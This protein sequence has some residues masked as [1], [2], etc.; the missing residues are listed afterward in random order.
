[1][2]H[3][4]G[5]PLLL[6]AHAFMSE[7][8]KHREACIKEMETFQD[9][10]SSYDV[11]KN[12]PKTMT[13]EQL[14]ELIEIINRLIQMFPNIFEYLCLLGNCQYYTCPINEWIFPVKT[15]NVMCIYH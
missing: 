10:S 2:A 1:M 5:L 8:N 14:L 3:L 11:F 4:R 12:V 13:E 6:V 7:I 9:R 15:N